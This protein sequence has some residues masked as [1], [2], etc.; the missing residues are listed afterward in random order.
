[1]LITLLQFEE[2]ATCWLAKASRNILHTD[3]IRFKLQRE[4]TYN[5][6]MIILPDAENASVNREIVMQTN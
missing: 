4:V 2:S 5:V 1:M 6:L 3:Q